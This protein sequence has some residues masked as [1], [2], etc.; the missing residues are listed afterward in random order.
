[1]DF[2][3][4]TLFTNSDEGLKRIHKEET[5]KLRRNEMVF[6]CLK[7][8]NIDDFTNISS[9]QKEVIEKALLAAKISDYF[10]DFGDGQKLLSK[11]K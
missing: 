7:K 1:M 2:L 9:E 6:D 5:E 3:D 8:I 4:K 11:F 10:D